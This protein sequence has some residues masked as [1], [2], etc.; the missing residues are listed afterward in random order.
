MKRLVPGEIAV[1]DHT[2]V[3]P[4][5]AEGLADSG[6]VAVLNASS[7]FSGRIPTSDRCNSSAPACVLLWTTSAPA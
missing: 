2:D 7:S 5:A 3:D 1:I 4:V 6:I